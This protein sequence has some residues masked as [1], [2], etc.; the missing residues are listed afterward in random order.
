MPYDKYGN[1]IKDPLKE[2]KI[3]RENM[4]AAL[5][6]RRCLNCFEYL[7]SINRDY[8][9]AEH[10]DLFCSSRC[11]KDKINNM[12]QALTLTDTL[13]ICARVAARA[14]GKE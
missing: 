14:A 4:L 13:D 2:G 12:L 7:V 3:L 11:E 8:N 1:E 5:R 6:Q 9:N 10:K